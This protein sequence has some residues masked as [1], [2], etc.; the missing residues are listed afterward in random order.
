MKKLSYIIVLVILFITAIA[1]GTSAQSSTFKKGGIYTQT[2]T[3]LGTVGKDDIIRNN[4]GQAM[5]F[6]DENGN[7]ANENGEILG[8]AKKSGSY[9]KLTGGNV[10]LTEDKDHA[11]CALLYPKGHNIGADHN[12]AKLHNCAAHC[13]ALLKQK[14]ADAKKNAPGVGKM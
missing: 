12:N 10:V 4:K 5:Y 8:K 13:A 6:I 11:Q 2:G 1:L 14:A 7:I 9:Y 3:Q